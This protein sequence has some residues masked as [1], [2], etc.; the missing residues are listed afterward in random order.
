[1]KGEGA[2]KDLSEL[3]AGYCTCTDPYSDN[4][5]SVL[6]LGPRLIRVFKQSFFRLG[7]IHC[8]EIFYSLTN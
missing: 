4:H 1:M 3:A 6:Q 8:F 2:E 5:A 7:E